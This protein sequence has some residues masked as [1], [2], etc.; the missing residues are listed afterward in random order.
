MCGILGGNLF[1]NRAQV[2]NAQELIA[3]RGRDASCA[4]SVDGVWMAHNRL[5]IQDLDEKANQPMVDNFNTMSL[6]FNGELWQRTI[7]KYDYLRRAYPFKTKKSDTELLL[8]MYR[9]FHKDVFI[10]LDGMFSFAIHDHAEQEIILARDWVGRLPLYYLHKYGGLA[11]SSELKVLTESFPDAATEIKVVP[12][13]SYCVYNIKTGDFITKRYYD[14][15]DNVRDSD[16]QLE[17]V[18]K[19]IRNRLTDAVSN[20]LIADVPVCTIL[21]GGIDSVLITYLLKQHLPDLKAY[22]V[23]VGGGNKDDLHFA[24]MAAE[25]L[26]IP[27]EEVIVTKSDINKRLK[28]SIWAA[29]MDSW[30][31]V[32]PA[33]AQLFLAKKISEDGFKVVFGGEGADELFGSYGNIQKMYYKQDTN[34]KARVG[35]IRNLHK[36]NLIRTNKAMMYGGTVELRTPFL[37]R[38]FAEYALSVVCI[39]AK[40]HKHPNGFVDIDWENKGHMKYP[41]R[42][43]F[44][45]LLAEGMPEELLYR[46]KETFQVGCHTD[47][48]RDEKEK[49]TRIYNKLFKFPVKKKEK[50][51]MV[52]SRILLKDKTDLDGVQEYLDYP[53]HVL[54]AMEK[55]TFDTA[56]IVLL[57]TKFSKVGKTTLEKYPNL[58]AVITRGHGSDYVDS[59]LCE[60]AGVKVYRT[61]PYRESCAEWCVDKV[62]ASTV[63]VYGM[64]GTIGSVIENILTTKGIE[65]YGVPSTAGITPESLSSIHGNKPVKTI[66]SCIPY[67]KK[68]Y[69]HNEH[70]FNREFFEQFNDCVDFI[71]I[72]RGPTH[73]NDDF[74]KLLEDKKIGNVHIDTVDSYNRDKLLE[75][76]NFHYYEHQAWDYVKLD[77]KE[78]FFRLNQQ[79]EYAGITETLAKAGKNED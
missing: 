32:T 38:E 24:R 51:K 61:N 68:R 46:K 71:S 37:D 58:K 77:P 63:L 72:S 79:I 59:A 69:K 35:L 66:I 73:N 8:Y 40:T 76:D 2:K 75:F 50:S 11:F 10:H 23:S 39:D 1:T 30:T 29:E 55:P 28:E 14:I 22:V 3:H 41:L 21:S 9:N 25:W 5:A 20:E 18:T 31:Q 33:V 34:Q 15:A 57:S 49:M 62:R 56:N 48:L 78:L 70:F 45:F 27:L 67:D 42:K 6:V 65:H 7:K 60:K 74:L 36:N 53:V 54:G 16:T 43:A 44:E 13:G 47:Y 17:E 12:P 4:F 64:D 26:D 19:Q 52:E